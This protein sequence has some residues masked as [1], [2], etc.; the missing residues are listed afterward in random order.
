MH[1]G[2][3]PSRSDS[4]PSKKRDEEKGMGLEG[5]DGGCEVEVH[6]IH[7]ATVGL[8]C[9]AGAERRCVGIKHSSVSHSR[10]RS[11]ER[12]RKQRAGVV[13]GH[14]WRCT[15]PMRFERD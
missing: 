4:S 5:G 15:R 14:E 8:A 7:A 10:E 6:L 2:R 3:V 1:D 11:G 12:V 13:L 9:R